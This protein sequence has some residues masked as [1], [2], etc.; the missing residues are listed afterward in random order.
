MI[1]IHD[2]F[3]EKTRV[4][5]SEHFSNAKSLC[6]FH[7]LSDFIISLPLEVFGTDSSVYV[8]DRIVRI[9]LNHANDQYRILDFVIHRNTFLITV[10][11]CFMKDS[12]NFQLFKNSHFRQSEELY[13]LYL[14]SLFSGAFS[15]TF[16]YRKNKYYFVEL[17]YDDPRLKN[18]KFYSLKS[19][20]LHRIFKIMPDSHDEFRYIA[21]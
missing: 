6:F 12:V 15:K 1:N 7:M 2:F 14:H 18:K 19:F 9:K 13:K 10:V 4:E 3:K 21:F 5:L 11:N 20:L 17:K 8:T 16:F